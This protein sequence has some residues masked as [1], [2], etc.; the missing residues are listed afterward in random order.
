MLDKTTIPH[1]GGYEFD[2]RCIDNPGRQEK[3]KRLTGLDKE[4][5][6]YISSD[7]QADKYFSTVLNLVELS[8]NSYI[9]YGYDQLS[10][11]FGCTGGQ[12]RS[13][14]FAEKL[15][16]TLESRKDIQM[17]LKHNQLGIILSDLNAINNK[18]NTSGNS[19]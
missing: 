18:D 16:E 10:V 17:T 6:E 2:C 3:F 11:G 9:N 8:L 7:N 12:H 13:V 15:K 4:V 14:Y 5:K 1:G 19:K